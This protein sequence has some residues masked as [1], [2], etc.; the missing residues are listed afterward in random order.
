[1][2]KTKCLLL[3]HYD[4]HKSHVH[5]RRKRGGAASPHTVCVWV[6]VCVFFSFSKLNHKNGV[7]MEALEA[8]KMQFAVPECRKWL[9]SIHF[10]PGE[11][12]PRPRQQPP[13]LCLVGLHPLEHLGPLPIL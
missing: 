7:K 4:K 10:F 8:D 11:H 13:K 3:Y 1:M 2:L 5:R 6:C 12:A 9:L